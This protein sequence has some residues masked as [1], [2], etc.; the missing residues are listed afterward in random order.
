SPHMIFPWAA[1]R[2]S[3]FNWASVT[4]TSA[5]YDDTT[6]SIS[7]RGMAFVALSTFNVTPLLAVTG[8]PSLDNNSQANSGRP[9]RLATRNGSSRQNNASMENFGN[10]QTLTVRAARSGVR[11]GG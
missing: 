5:W 11:T 8:L 3:H 4:V 9:K 10:S 7:P 6:A 1:T 2:R